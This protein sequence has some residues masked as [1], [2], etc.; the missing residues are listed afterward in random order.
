MELQTRIDID[1][2]KALVQTYQKKESEALLTAKL[3]HKEGNKE[4]ARQFI[5]KSRHYLKII[6]VV[7][8]RITLL[9]KRNVYS[10][11]IAQ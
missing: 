2:Y 3:Y 10:T 5:N 11:L 8:D 7:K 9:E 6:Y 1:K 4:M